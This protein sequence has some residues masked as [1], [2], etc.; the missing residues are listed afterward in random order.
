MNQEKGNV[1]YLPSRVAALEQLI[2]ADRDSLAPDGT[3]E[4]M[5]LKTYQLEKLQEALDSLSDMDRELIRER[6]YEGKTEREVCADFGLAKTTLCQ[7]E[8][9]FWRS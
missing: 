2:E 1:L 9:P 7:R 3:A 4:D 5:V 6:F 8:K